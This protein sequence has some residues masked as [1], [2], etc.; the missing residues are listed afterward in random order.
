MRYVTAFL[1]KF[2]LNLSTEEGWRKNTKEKSGKQV[3][4]TL[5][6]CLSDYSFNSSTRLI[7]PVHSRFFWLFCTTLFLE[8]G[9]VSCQSQLCYWWCALDRSITSNM[10]SG[11]LKGAITWKKRH[12]QRNRFWQKS[13]G[14]CQAEWNTGPQYG[15]FKADAYL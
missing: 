5:I 12:V 7:T 1:S 14:L 2:S 10:Y 3:F 11:T 6:R 13:Y 9:T 8:K 4:T 15:L